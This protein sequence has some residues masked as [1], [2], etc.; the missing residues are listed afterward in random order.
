[1]GRSHWD[2]SSHRDS[3]FENC[4][5]NLKKARIEEP[6]DPAIYYKVNL[7]GEIAEDKTIDCVTNYKLFRLGF[8]TGNKKHFCTKLLVNTPIYEYS[9]P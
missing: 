4:G 2:L 1:M 8:E 5:K 6:T 3:R 7:K 9:E